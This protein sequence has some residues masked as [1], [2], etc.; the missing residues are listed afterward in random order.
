MAPA[1]TGRSE[2]VSRYVKRRPRGEPNDETF[3]ALVLFLGPLAFV[4]RWGLASADGASVWVG[5]PGRR[6]N[7]QPEPGSTAVPRNAPKPL[8]GSSTW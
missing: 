8:E 3:I 1:A 2:A 5:L 6:V 4:L 7:V